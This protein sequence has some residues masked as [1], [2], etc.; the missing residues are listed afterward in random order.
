[1]ANITHNT[2]SI[3]QAIEALIAENAEYMP[4][5][6]DRVQADDPDTYPLQAQPLADGTGNAAEIV[7]ADNQNNLYILTISPQQEPRGSSS[8][9]PGPCYVESREGHSPEYNSKVSVAEDDLMDRYGYQGI[10]TVAEAG[11]EDYRLAGVHFEADGR[12]VR[13]VPLPGDDMP[14][15]PFE[16]GQRVRVQFAAGAVHDTH[17]RGGRVEAEYEP[18]RYRI[19]LDNPILP[20]SS[21]SAPRPAR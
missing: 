3:A 21:S 12:T 18:S 17:V 9:Q 2:T 4:D 7:V 15:G 1:M 13:I 10:V 8:E 5:I 16:E 19:A 11:A 20:G 6:L 14:P